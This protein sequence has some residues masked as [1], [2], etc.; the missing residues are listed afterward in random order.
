V[1]GLM[2]DPLLERGDLQYLKRH[3]LKNNVVLFLGAG[4]S[5]KATN[6]L[7]QSLPT[8]KELAKAL[9]EYM[10]YPD[11]YDETPLGILYQAAL[12]KP[13]GT[14]ALRSLL[15]RNLQVVEFPDWYGLVS[16]WFWYRIYTTNVDNLVELIFKSHG[17]EAGLS[18]IVA[19]S[20]YKDR[21]QFLRTLQYV[22]LNGSLE[23]FDEGLTFDPKE[24]GRR[25]AE[26]DVWYDHFVRDFSTLPTVF[27]GSELEEP[28]FWQYLAIRQHRARHGSERR[29]QSF[30]V[31]P[32]ISAA[33]RDALR[34]FNVKPVEATAEQFLRELASEPEIIVS[35]Q[36]VLHN[37]DPTL[38]ELLALE[39]AGLP[40]SEVALAEEFFAV[41]RPV[42]G[43]EPVSG[44]RSHFLLGSP[45]TWSDIFNHFDADREINR[46]LKDSVVSRLSDEKDACGLVVLT[47]AAGS[48]K[49]TIAKRVSVMLAGE[50][51]SVYFADSTARFL[52][53]QIVE[54]LRS[55][56]R[57]ITLVFDDATVDLRRVIELA[58]MCS[59]L[60]V[61]PVI[62][63]TIRSN[64]LAVKRYLFEDI[65]VLEVRV[66]DL[67]E[68]DIRGILATLENNGLL[69][70]LRRLSLEARADVFREKARKQILV[71][72]RE[73]TRGLG[74]DEIIEDEY[75]KTQP[76]EA[77]LVYL[78]AAI[79]SALHYFVSRGQLVAAMD[80][81][82]SE[83]LALID[84][85]L[86][87]ILLPRE[88][89]PDQL[90]IRHP[91][92]A[93][94]ILHDVA[95]RELLAQ[96]Y[97]VYLRLLAHDLPSVKDRKKSR[98]FRIYQEVINHKNLHETF[99]RQ[100][101]LCRS[102]YE[103]LKA[104]LN[105]DGHYWLQYGSYELEWGDLDFAENYLLQSESLMPNHPWVGTA[106]GYLL[107]RKAVE[108]TSLVGAKEL[109]TKGL[110]KLEHQIETVGRN[111]PYPYHVLG[112]QMLAFINRWT[113]MDLR[114]KELQDL[115]VRVMEGMKK[116]RLDNHL[117]QLA[118]DIKH[119]E[120]DTIG[121]L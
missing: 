36:Q 95:P 109:L 79:P 6:L 94:H 84:D 66:P 63:V 82:P 11:S 113:P 2:A 27:I 87:G 91:V 49:T 12:R 16:R 34:E 68:S 20:E 1:K 3:L 73:A 115:H 111:D 7:G 75:N 37:L 67:S 116:H 39:S 77:K 32:H 83:T 101:E 58:S 86:S 51:F 108:A 107:M 38:E 81:P 18:Q 90:Q 72:M 65:N 21:D 106:L 45:P 23:K 59:R 50:G 117:R 97:T 57:R 40:H 17:G 43:E 5:I 110:E 52:P 96:A 15:E 8:S 47:G 69:G 9:F 22:K 114:I 112:A 62:V 25:A 46:S 120:L 80:L 26:R 99:L 4:F 14:S 78:I 98:T 64:D 119:A 60:K 71:A 35:R 76:R 24:Y 105:D 28:L 53:E 104:P 33:K 54:Y 121:Q 30:L 118:D 74:F 44:L 88:A 56:E 70:D 93:E 61:R 13:G 92:I 103:S 31:C 42:R 29:R 41:F 85:S 89:N 102:I 55:Y 10:D 100:V 19:P 48:G